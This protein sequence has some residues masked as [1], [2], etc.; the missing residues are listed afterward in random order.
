[1]IEKVEKIKSGDVRTASRLIR[2][3]ENGTD[4]ARA[5]MKHIF[6]LTGRAH[7]VGVTGSPGAGKSTLLDG[8]VEQFR[9]NEKT[10]GVL[11]VDP[12]SPFTGGAILGDRIRMQ[13]HAEDTGVFVRSLATRGALGGL[14]KA[15]G[16]AVHIMDAMGKD[17]ILVETVGTGQQEVDII[18]HSHTVVVVLVPG[19]GDEIQAIKAGVMEIADIFVINKAD[20]DGAAKLKR[21]L[22]ILLDM[23]PPKAF[24]AGWRPPVVEVGNAF[25]PASFGMS[26]KGLMETIEAHYRYLMD[27]DLMRSRIRRRATV[28]LHE[29]IRAFI[30][31]PVL[32]RLAETGE[33]ERMIEKM[34]VKEADP[35]SLAEEMAKKYIR[36]I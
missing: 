7:V 36:E 31:E 9:K 28:E 3:L 25:D 8:L 5:V 11:A 16:D 21:E 27:H 32:N 34:L 23:A 29:A 2:Q 17:R 6:P 22:T 10:V 35:Y 19:M 24:A 20:R 18:N 14:A 1:M 15:V 26:V 12:T 33:T 13:R 30:L 4:E